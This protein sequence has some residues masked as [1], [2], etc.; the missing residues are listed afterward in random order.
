[1]T[2]KK[3][4]PITQIKTETITARENEILFLYL[5]TNCTYVAFG[6]R[7]I[8]CMILGPLNMSGNI[9]DNN[10]TTECYVSINDGRSIGWMTI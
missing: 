5:E 1:M 3:K 6:I 7:I 4:D 2:K 10:R 9:F 8:K